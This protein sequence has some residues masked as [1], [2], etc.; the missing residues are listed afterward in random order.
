M[1]V[2]LESG[3]SSGISKVLIRDVDPL[4]RVTFDLGSLRDLARKV[5][6]ALLALPSTGGA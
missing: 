6:I 3:V 1:I 2:S 4:S 5:A